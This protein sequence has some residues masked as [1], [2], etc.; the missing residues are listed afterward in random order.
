VA[1]VRSPDAPQMAAHAVGVGSK[2]G[3]AAPKDV[4]VRKGRTSVGLCCWGRAPLSTQVRRPAELQ[5]SAGFSC[6]RVPREFASNRS[7]V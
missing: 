4:L 3:G 1:D 2:E 6:M 5:S 7:R